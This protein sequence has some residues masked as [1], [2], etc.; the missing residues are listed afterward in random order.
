MLPAI[1]DARTRLAAAQ[2]GSTQPGADLHAELGL[3]GLSNSAPVALN[4]LVLPGREHASLAAAS[5]LKEPPLPPPKLPDI[6][7]Y[8]SR[9][10]SA[11]GSVGAQ[12]DA[13][14]VGSENIP[15]PALIA[16]APALNQVAAAALA[17]QP[18]GVQQ[19][20][21]PQAPML[22]PPPAVA[23]AAADPQQPVQ[24]RVQVVTFNMAG[25]L[26]AALPPDFF[27]QDDRHV[28]V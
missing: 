7:A 8:R 15:R 20:A 26:P 3:L 22:G 9:A 28:D 16:T 1:P 25:T 17:L 18:Q 19:Q 13:P 21:A 5:S 12:S 14:S 24:L 4:D 27:R 6:A 2:R 10:A 11:A 23:V